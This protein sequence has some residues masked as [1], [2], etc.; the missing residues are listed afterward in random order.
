MTRQPDAAAPA[1]YSRAQADPPPP[2]RNCVNVSSNRYGRR[3]VRRESH[4]NSGSCLRRR[5]RRRRWSCTTGLRGAHRI[6]VAAT[7]VRLAVQL[8]TPTGAAAAGAHAIGRYF[9]EPREKKH[10]PEGDERVRLGREHVV[11][12]VEV[13]R[14]Q[15]GIR[16][17]AAEWGI[18]EP[19]HLNEHDADSQLTESLAK[20][21]K[22]KNT[23]KKTRELQFWKMVVRGGRVCGQTR[24]I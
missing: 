6:S 7:R 13:T 19:V 18:T 23:R 24:K 12:P 5:R 20:E 4:W 1:P 2:R 11:L 10:Q 17:V 21:Q 3:L 9:I 22:K 15:N 16:L 14:I 8:H